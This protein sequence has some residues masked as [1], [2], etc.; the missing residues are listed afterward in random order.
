MNCNSCGTKMKENLKTSPPHIFSLHQCFTLQS[1]QNSER[2]CAAILTH[3]PRKTHRFFNIFYGMK[4][5]RWWGHVGKELK[6]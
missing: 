4:S 3:N 1:R 5:G 2:N 6:Q